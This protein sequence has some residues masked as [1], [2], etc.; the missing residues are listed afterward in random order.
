MYMRK[1]IITLAAVF[2]AVP[3]SLQAAQVRTYQDGLKRAGGDKPLVV[4]C[5]G[6]NYDRYSEKIY[7]K[8]IKHRNNPLGRVLS[9]EAYV[10]VPIYQQPSA[11]EKREFERV[12]G[13]GRRLP[14]GIRSYPCLALVDGRGNFRGAVESAADFESPEK[15]AE[16]LAAL[17]EDFRRQQKLLDRAERLKGNAHDA[18]LREALN[19]TSVRVPGHGMCDPAND[20]LGEKLQLMSIEQANEHVRRT[21]ASGNFTLVE[22]QMMLVALAGHMRRKNAAVH[23]LRAIFTEIRNIDPKSSYGAYAEG[24]LELWVI[25]KEQEMGSKKVRTM[26]PNAPAE[27]QEEED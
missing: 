18:V 27:L 8:Y 14:G 3:C 13:K 23:R 24:A 22:R 26:A 21:I 10:V 20:G 4:F 15:A 9:R 25:P 5:Y 1:F 12:M 17:L 11:V 6:A 7:D 16:S 19:I 2:A